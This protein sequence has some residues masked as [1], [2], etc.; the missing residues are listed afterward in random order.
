VPRGNPRC[1]SSDKINDLREKGSWKSGEGR[2]LGLENKFLDYLHW[3]GEHM[4]KIEP[5]I[6]TGTVNSP[7]T[8]PLYGVRLSTLV[9]SFLFLPPLRV[10]DASCVFLLQSVVS[11]HLYA[12]L[13]S[14][15]A[16][17]KPTVLSE[18][19]SFCLPYDICTYKHLHHPSGYENAK[20]T[21][22]ECFVM[23]VEL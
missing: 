8:I 19:L 14:T 21:W 15:L 9:S 12:T 13:S 7:E 10:S 3:R 5:G 20:G 4:Q 18:K 23:F 1:A 2:S 6:A 17:L 16:A 22:L 11:K